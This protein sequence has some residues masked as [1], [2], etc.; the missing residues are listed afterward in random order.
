MRYFVDTHIP[1]ESEADAQEVMRIL[2]AVCPDWRPTLMVESVPPEHPIA[3]EIDDGVRIYRI[4]PD[5]STTLIR[6][7][8]VGPTGSFAIEVGADLD[9]RGFQAIAQLIAA[10][11]GAARR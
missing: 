8:E 1:C 9:E 11:S 3:A 5:G 6:A 10:N 2:T 4:N 7:E